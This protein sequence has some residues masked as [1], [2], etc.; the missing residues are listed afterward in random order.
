MFELNSTIK[1]TILIQTKQKLVLQGKDVSLAVHTTNKRFKR[2]LDVIQN[3]VYYY[4]TLQHYY[5][6]ESLNNIIIRLLLFDTAINTLQYTVHWANPKNQLDPNAII[7]S[8]TS[9]QS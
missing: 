6:S 9:Y 7:Q 8:P 1:S 5:L 4:T 3:H 2:A